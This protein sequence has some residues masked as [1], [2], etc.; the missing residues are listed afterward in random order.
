M[1]AYT[2]TFEEIAAYLENRNLY[3]ILLDPNC[4]YKVVNT[5]NIKCIIN[6]IVNYNKLITFVN[7]FPN[8]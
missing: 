8:E 5:H 7:R 2:G 1:P 3:R 6:L 4:N